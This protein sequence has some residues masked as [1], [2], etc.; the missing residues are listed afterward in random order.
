MASEIVFLKD[1]KLRMLAQL[2]R[3]HEVN[4][5]QN[6][7][8]ESIGKQFEYLRM[9]NSNQESVN[10][11]LDECNAMVSKYKDDEI[12][13]PISALILGYI[14]NCLNN[15]LQL[16]RNYTLR[17]TYLDKL[18]AHDL[19]LFQALDGLDTS[20]PTEV[21]DFTDQI[22]QYDQKVIS[23][24]KL[25]V[26]T[27]ASQEFSRYLRN[28]GIGFDNLVR[29]YQ[30]RLGFT[31]PFKDLKDEQKLEV[32]DAIIE[33]SGRLSVLDDKG[34][35]A[36]SYGK[37]TRSIKDY[38]Q[39]G[40]FL[41]KVGIIIWDIYS[42]D[43][44]IQTAT[45]EAMVQAAKKGGATL[46]KIVGAAAATQLVGVQATTLFVTA[47]GLAGGVVGGFIFGAAAGL[48][49]DLIFGSGGEAVLP[50]D[51]LIF[52]V[53]PMPNGKDLAKQI[54]HI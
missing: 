3:N 41:M 25:S 38:G 30:T 7:I 16:I 51:G 40:M 15:A 48:L 21:A 47:L 24:M 2:I 34:L 17:R 10:T 45:R 12:R 18:I 37:D 39:K 9:C 49:F 22:Q 26:N 32:Y 13:G 5:I 43:Q 29:S 46:G 54:A 14:E 52:Y 8:F 44:P 33:A 35:K 23:Y 19:E 36:L 11:V 31:G 4:N 28:S 27:H 20:N 53:A 1:E 50:T 42:S 6:I